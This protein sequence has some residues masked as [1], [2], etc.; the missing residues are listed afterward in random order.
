MKKILQVVTV[1]KLDQNYNGFIVEICN[2]IKKETPDF[3]EFWLYHENYGIKSLMFGCNVIDD[4]IVDMI[5]Y[6][7]D[8]HIEIYQKEYMED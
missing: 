2:S 7:I 4:D 6:N 5:K 8:H 3:K 1:Y